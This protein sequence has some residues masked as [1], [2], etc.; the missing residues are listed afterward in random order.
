VNFSDLVFLAQNYNTSLPTAP[1]PGAPADFQTDLA[2]AFASV[3]EPST[4]VLISIA[5]AIFHLKRRRAR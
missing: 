1:I 2:A 5:G 3:P 4:T